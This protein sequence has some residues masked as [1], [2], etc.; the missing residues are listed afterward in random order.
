MRLLDAELEL[1]G[2]T[3]GH[4]PDVKSAARLVGPSE[5]CASVEPSWMTDYV[6]ETCKCQCPDDSCH[7]LGVDFGTEGAATEQFDDVE[8][9][10][11]VLHELLRLLGDS[12]TEFVLLRN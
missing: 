12:A 11:S 1:V 10:V 5:K 6:R 3:R 8:S 4:G 2:A 9:V 7:V